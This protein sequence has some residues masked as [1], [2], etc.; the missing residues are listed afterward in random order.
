MSTTTVE[1]HRRRPLWPALRAAQVLLLLPFG[2]LQLTAVVASAATMEPTAG[3]RALA[4][5]AVALGVAG[6]ALAL[7]LPRR[8]HLIRGAAFVLLRCQVAFGLVNLIVLGEWASLVLLALAGA[9]WLLV[10]LDERLHPS[11]L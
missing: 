2:A 11:V 9:T 7:L 4:A 1:L 10:R 8:T 3:G 6:I 5:W